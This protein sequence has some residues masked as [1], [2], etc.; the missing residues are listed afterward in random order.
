M[1]DTRLRS[2]GPD[3]SW[4]RRT[5][6][7]HRSA[8]TQMI[9]GLMIMGVG[10]VLVLGHFGV[11]ETEGVWPRLWPLLLVTAGLGKL[12]T[13]HPDGTRRGG[14]LL[15]IGIWLL[16]SQLHIWRASA[17]WPL[18]LVAFGISIVW[19]AVMVPARRVE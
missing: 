7:D 3:E 14:S 18:F 17:S 12:F 10:V 9:A 2:V 13:P 4:G 16:L 19:N 1:P 15:L 11:V 5:G 8:P 6:L